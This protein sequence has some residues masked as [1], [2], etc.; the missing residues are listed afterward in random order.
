MVNRRRSQESAGRRRCRW[1]RR[2][3]PTRRSLSLP[4]C[5]DAASPAGRAEGRLQTHRTSK[6]SQP[7]SPRR[8]GSAGRS[9]YS[10]LPDASYDYPSSID[11]FKEEGVFQGLATTR[12][13]GRLFGY[14]VDVEA[15]V[16]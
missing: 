1:S 6:T 12:R 15:V 10:V 11:L 5:W 16:S 4:E 13:L 7:P 14:W 9:W 8:E 2:S 3:G